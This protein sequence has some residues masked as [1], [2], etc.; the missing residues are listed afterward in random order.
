MGEEEPKSTSTAMA[1]PG[2]GVPALT[3][4]AVP[5]RTKTPTP[6]REPVPVPGRAQAMWGRQWLRAAQAPRS[7]TPSE[8]VWSSC[9]AEVSR[10]K[11]LRLDAAVQL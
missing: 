3:E 9:T 2:T 7:A 4:P 6:P 1:R 5:A 11:A 10:R 8:R